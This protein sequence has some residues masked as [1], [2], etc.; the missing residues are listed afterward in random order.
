MALD[1]RII[2]GGNS[3]NVF[4]NFV[5]GQQ[6][7][8]Q[9]AEA[10]RQ[11]ALAAAMQEHGAGLVQ[12]DEQAI[13]ALAA[14]DPAYV[15]GVQ[16]QRS[17]MTDRDRRFGLSEEM[18]RAQLGD[19]QARLELA[20]AQAGRQAQELGMRMDEATRKR[21]LEQLTQGLAMGTQAQTPEQ[22]D[23]IMSRI[24]PD[25]VGQFENRDVLIAGALGVKDALEMSQPG[26]RQATPEEAAQY[27]AQAGQFGPDG[28][29]YPIN[30]PSGMS[31]RQTGDGFEFVQG[32]GAGMATPGA[33]TVPQ[34]YRMVQDESDPQGYRLE[35]IPGGP[36][37]QEAAQAEQQAIGRQEQAAAVA[38]TVLADVANAE[39]ILD[40]L[41][42]ALARDGVI[43]GTLRR[44]MGQVPGSEISRLNSWMESARSNIAL[45]TLQTM[46]DN[47]PTGGALGNVSDRQTEMLQSVL[48]QY[49][50]EMNISEIK[51]VLHRYR[52]HYLDVVYGTASERRRAL[53]AGRITPEQFAQAE[54]E[55]AAAKGEDTPQGAPQPGVTEDGYR[56]LGGDPGDPANWQKVN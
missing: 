40:G 48:G 42:G 55:I 17:Q 45:D 24:A 52:D 20:Y 35:P 46:R 11:N 8:F 31:L 25:Y 7:G 22:W 39:S 4:G 49:K 26:F 44:Q 15:V 1:P 14:L 21:E 9:A 16:N 51:E 34:G 27:G 3:P 36:V 29:F 18:Q 6:A 30:P 47:S 2:L 38:R 28:R 50:P 56:F 10:Q 43:G 23:A 19:M 33:G 12:G 53:E 13:N 5:A 41:G 32:P 37:A 54:A